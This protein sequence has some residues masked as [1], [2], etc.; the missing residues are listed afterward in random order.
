MSY[1]EEHINTIIN[2]DCLD[3]LKQLPDKCI[4][5]VLTDPP[6]GMLNNKF[7]KEYFDEN[8]VFN[9]L[10][11]ILKDDGLIAFSGRGDTLYHWN[12]IL[13]RASIPFKEEIIWV[14]NETTSPVLA[15][16]RN[17]ELICIRGKG[18]L[19]FVYEDYIKTCEE[20]ERE[21]LIISTLKR[22][23]SDLKKHKEEILNLIETGK[24]EYKKPKSVKN[25]E[26][27]GAIRETSRGIT[28]F[29]KLF[30]KGTGL[31]SCIF[32]GRDEFY[33]S[34][35]P[36][37]KPVELWQKI[38]KLCSNENDLVLDCFS[39]SGTTAIA[40]HNLKRNFICI[41]KDFDYWKAS[42]KRLEEHKRQL[43]LF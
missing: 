5:L 9:N 3:I 28:D 39:G 42:C 43:T 4:D 37:Q 20:E 26:F 14:K 41:E 23:K 40:C 7:D 33:T 8:G 2:A 1:L 35:H 17:H 16:K 22:I 19:N 31:K 25:K 11:R 32:C 21:Y 27:V 24:F 18:K 29:N 15:L 6:Y 30:I 10:A 38:I 12:A 34:I 13:E 36:T